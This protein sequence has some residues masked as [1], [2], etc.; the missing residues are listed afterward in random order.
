MF[1]SDVTLS[2][3]AVPQKG[4]LL[5]ACTLW[6]AYAF[7]FVLPMEGIAVIPILGR[8]SRAIGL[9]TA[10]SW[11]LTVLLEGR[12]R[13]LR[14]VHGVIFFFVFWNGLSI[15]WSLDTTGTLGRFFTYLQLAVL[16]VIVFDLFKTR[17]AMKAG[18]QAYVLG[19]FVSAVNTAD[20]YLHGVSYYFKR[21][22]AG[23]LQVNDLGLILALGIPLA[24]YLA[25]IEKE[26]RQ[27][28]WLKLIN[29]AYLPM[30]FFGI[31]LTASR[32]ALLAALPG[33]LF[34]AW[35]FMSRLSAGRR[36][37]LFVLTGIS[38]IAVLPFIP[39]ASLRRYSETGTAVTEG[40]LAGRLA[41]WRDGLY[42]FFDHPI[43]GVGSRAF[44]S[45]AEE[46]GHVAHNF[47]IALLVELGVIGFII[48]AVVLLMTAYNA[49][50]Q[51]KWIRR[52]WLTVLL[53]WFLGASFHNWEHRKQTWL[54]LSLVT[55]SRGVYQR[56]YASDDKPAVFT[57]GNAF[58]RSSM[59]RGAIVGYGKVSISGG[60]Y[61]P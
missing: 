14:M 44:T 46:T 40:G 50:L 13:H 6:W 59:R 17:L 25:M 58:N 36:L 16:A 26:G 4:S 10:A 48:Y 28:L 31:F 12:F 47:V 23:G 61:H 8:V 33:C 1:I 20:N 49:A 15:F 19:A 11:I 24:W 45:A 55:A 9:V 41:T 56:R 3:P 27:S 39:E 30:G 38:I 53:S 18:M 22:S 42:V 52:L 2:S 37:L 54:F 21:Y 51:P 32:A 43:L 60:G 57:A 7:I 34:I 35:S 29:L 5:R